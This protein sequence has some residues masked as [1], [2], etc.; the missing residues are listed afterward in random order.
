M[1]PRPSPL[2]LALPL[3][4]GL[5]ASLAAALPAAPTRVKA[6]FVRL[7]SFAPLALA[8][9][10]GYF[11]AQGLDVELVEIPGLG[12][13]TPALARGEL[14]VGAGLVRIADLNAIARGAAIRIVADKGHSEAGACPS[15]AL[16]ASREFLGGPDPASPARLKGAKVSAPPLSLAEFALDTF[17]SGRGLKLSDVDAARL[18]QS[19]AAEALARGALDLAVLT[20]PDLSRTVGSGRAALWKPV[21][22]ILPGA[23]MAVLLY[24]PGLLEKNREAGT[25]FMAAYLQGV[26]QYNRGKTDR[27]VELLAAATGLDAALLKRSCWQAIRGDGRVNVE[28]VL[29]FQRWAVKRGALDAVVPAERFWD[30]SFVEAAGKALGPPAP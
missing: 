5:L 18:Q 26:R 8:R 28:S 7:T 24:G 2:L 14:D 10:E 23:Q 4:A 22:E 1:T 19:V 27:N 11:R 13:A 17:L 30:P 12:D 16:V 6:Q 9:D 3:A 29:A 20:E 21:E 25:R 15:S